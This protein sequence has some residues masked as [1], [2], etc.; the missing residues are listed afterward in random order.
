MGTTK[1]SRVESKFQGVAQGTNPLSISHDQPIPGSKR[2]ATKDDMH[3]AEKKETSTARGLP[4]TSANTLLPAQMQPQLNTIGSYGN[5]G[6]QTER[7]SHSGRLQSQTIDYTRNS[8][9]PADAG[10]PASSATLIN[11]I[12]NFSHAN[13]SHQRITS[14]H[15]QPIPQYRKANLRDIRKSQRMAQQSRDKRVDDGG[16]P[17]L[18]GNANSI[19]P[20]TSI[21]LN[22]NLK[23]GGASQ[24][25]QTINKYGGYANIQQF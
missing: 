1:V 12:G 15:S 7:P 13:A 10:A 3:S 17:D 18:Y 11:S 19:N 16:R 25:A 2:G 23:K 9:S 24:Q 20:L 8:T 5:G 6:G 4:S 22:S 21:E 14:Q